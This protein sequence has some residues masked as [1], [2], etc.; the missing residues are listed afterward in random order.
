MSARRISS[1]GQRGIARGGRD[2][3][4]E[5]DLHVAIHGPDGC[6]DY[7]GEAPAQRLGIRRRG[8]P[9]ADNDELV[10][11]HA[12]DE[13]A[14][15]GGHAQPAADLDQHHVARGM[16]QCIVD[17]LEAI[18]IEIEQCDRLVVPSRGERSFQEIHQ[19]GAVGQAGQGIMPRQM[20][21][22]AAGRLQVACALLVDAGH[23]QG[24]AQYRQG[25]QKRGRS[26]RRP[27]RAGPAAAWRRPGRIGLPGED[28][29][30]HHA[31]G[32]QRQTVIAG[33]RVGA[34][35]RQQKL[36]G[37]GVEL[38][39]RQLL[40]EQP[41]PRFVP[42]AASRLDRLPWRSPRRRQVPERHPRT[43][44]RRPEPCSGRRPD[45]RGRSRPQH[46]PA[47][48]LATGASVFLPSTTEYCVWSSGPTTN[49]NSYA[50]SSNREEPKFP[51]T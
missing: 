30:R 23:L 28:L 33:G 39:R 6:G 3:D 10:A 26:K 4:R 34:Q 42:G 36:G 44:P 16:A 48:P 19:H 35:R 2:A 49:M 31:V 12:C 17:R 9:G 27:P 8:K 29:V 40:A 47:A 46:R 38:R 50:N 43:K 37:N 14:F 18:E 45:E 41:A 13:V 20:L 22:P 24:V 7:L 11:A 15:A 51:F 32:A 21:G 25:Q 5:P 1:L